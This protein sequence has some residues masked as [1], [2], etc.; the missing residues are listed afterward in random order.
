MKKM[1]ASLGLIALSVNAFAAQTYFAPLDVNKLH[2]KEVARERKGEAP[3]FAVPHTV[4]IN[5]AA[6][7]SWVEKDGMM[8]W[9]HRFTAPNAVSLNFGFSKFHMSPNAR[10]EIR[11][12]D[13]SQAIRPFTADDNNAARELW[14]PIIMSDD[15]TVE[16]TVPAAEF[17]QVEF[18]VGTVGQGFRTFAQKTAKAG[19]CNID[20]V[21]SEGDGWRKEINAVAVISTGG[22]R[23]CTGFMVNNTSNDRTPYFMTA[24][25]CRINARTATSLVTYWNY[26][27]KQ[28][29]GARNGELGQFNTGSV[30]ISGSRKS[31][32]ALVKLNKAPEAA[33]GVTYAGWDRSG[34][35]ASQAIAIHHPNTDAKSISFENDPTQVTTY[36][37]DQ[38]PG[39]GTH[40]RVV[41]WDMG[42]TEP[43]SS[44]SPLFN[45]D[46]RV[47]GQLHGGWASCES[48]TSDYYGRLYTSWEGD[49]TPAS[50][51]KDHLDAANLG[52][53]VTDTLE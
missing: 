18:E 13:F 22:S 45:Q 15:V 11:S 2:D 1:I 43:G 51:L 39:D 33:W 25:H 35:D 7:K 47:I 52:S 20:V 40:V 5:P 42:T 4:S 23:F 36:L 53:M 21:C 9:S 16:L 30:Y 31:D 17:A 50:R 27:T 34:T 38:V 8:V 19:E 41:D 14:T 46:H 32:F 24:D 3:H 12:T 6:E 10:V 37:G 48:Q 49:G 29:G 44:G 28:C 26:Q